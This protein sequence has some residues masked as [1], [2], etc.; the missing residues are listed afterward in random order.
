MDGNGFVVYDG[1]AYPSTSFVLIFR[2]ELELRHLH[3]DH[4]PQDEWELQH[5]GIPWK[6]KYDAV[7]KIRTMH[8]Q[9]EEFSKCQVVS[10][11]GHVKVTAD[12]VKQ[13]WRPP[14]LY[15]SKQKICR[16][17]KIS[18]NCICE[19][20]EISYQNEPLEF[21]HFDHLDIDDKGAA[22]GDMTIDKTVTIEV[23]EAEIRKCR[24]ICGH[25]HA[26][27]TAEQAKSGILI[28]KRNN[29]IKKRKIDKQ[30]TH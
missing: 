28:A 10:L 14:R 23:F 18:R 6:Q 8:G 20:C 21:M 15:Q 29:T 17:Y 11:L 4:I 27:V 24:L 3:N 16:D 7:G 30:T 26:M 25:C 2:D 5:P 9:D 19:L 12:R 1:S 22:V 13:K